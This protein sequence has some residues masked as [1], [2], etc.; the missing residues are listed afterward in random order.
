[1]PEQ[2]RRTKLIR[3]LRNGQITI[4]A[5]FRRRL[6]ITEAT[7]LLMSLQD[8]ELRLKPVRL[9]GEDEGSPWLQAAFEAFAEVRGQTEKFSEE[10]IDAAIRDA[11]SAVRRSRD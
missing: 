3:Q 7:V 9:S 6:G 10:E 1:V 5:E 8:G 4:P 11:V 2:E